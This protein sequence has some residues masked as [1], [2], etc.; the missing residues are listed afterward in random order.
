VARGPRAFSRSFKPKGIN[1]NIIN[2]EDLAFQL[3]ELYRM[4]KG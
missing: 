3:F 2:P 1:Q 4:E